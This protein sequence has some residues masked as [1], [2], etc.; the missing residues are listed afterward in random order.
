MY[1]P[2]SYY[3]Y[4]ALVVVWKV[5]Q[6]AH[7]S[8]KIEKTI[9]V[10]RWFWCEDAEIKRIEQYKKLPDSVTNW[11]EKVGWAKNTSQILQNMY[12]KFAWRAFRVSEE[13]AGLGRCSFKVIIFCKQI[14]IFK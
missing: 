9:G 7:R 2:L 8:E 5:F 14:C 10:A 13:M 11:I 4:I 1:R 12:R 6:S 3:T